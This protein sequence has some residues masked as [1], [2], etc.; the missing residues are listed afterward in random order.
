L[1]REGGDFVSGQFED[2]NECPGVGP[3]IDF[4]CELP[5]IRRV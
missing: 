5:A 2:V 3:K 1:L 4:A